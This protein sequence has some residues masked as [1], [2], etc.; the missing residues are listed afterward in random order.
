MTP[1]LE[2]QFRSLTEDEQHP[3]FSMRVRNTG[4]APAIQVVG[5]THDIANLGRWAVIR[6]GDL[7]PS[8]TSGKS[9]PLWTKGNTLKEPWRGYDLER[10]L[11]VAV[12]MCSDVL[13]RR[14]RFGYAQPAAS[15]PGDAPFLRALPVQVSTITEDHPAHDTWVPHNICLGRRVD[16]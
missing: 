10:E 4:G 7:I 16:A 3:Y 9:E 2:L 5:A 14:F 15:P 6:F 11:V 13:G 8:E 1:N 12:L